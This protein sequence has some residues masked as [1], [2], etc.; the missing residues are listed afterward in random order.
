MF[1][2]AEL[3]RTT[4]KADYDAAL[5][6]LRARLLAAQRE[7]RGTRR[8]VIIVVS[9]VEGAGK[10]QVVNRLHEWLDA[11]GLTTH[12]FW[13]DS[14]EETERP[15][16]WRFW[17]ALPARGTIGILFGSWYTQ[18]IIDRV[19]GRSRRADLDRDLQRIAFFE[20]ML[21]D[22]GAVII[23]LW[24]HL[25][26]KEAKRR[27]KKGSVFGRFARMYDRFATVSERAIRM[28]DTAAAPW[29]I[30]EATDARYRDLTVGRIV[31][32]VLENLPRPAEKAAPAPASQEQTE[33][34]LDKVDLSK[35][36]SD[37]K[38]ERGL[39]KL[40]AEI[41]RLAWKAWNKRRSTV[42]LF[43]GWDA[44]GKGGA[45]RRLIAPI[46]ARLYRVIS[47][48]APTDE[49]R[50]R[51]YLWRFWRQLPRDGAMTLYDRSWYGRVLVE[52]VEGFAR[53]EEW[54]R[55][56]REIN[57]F[58][59][60]LVEHGI[61]LVKFWLHIDKAEQLRRFEERQ[62]IAFKQHKITDEDWRNREKWDPYTLAVH[63]MISRT[64]SAIAPWTIVAANDKR[65]A[66]LQVL[67]TVA[68]SLR[69]ED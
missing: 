52:R 10:S 26:E 65:L 46:D 59:E 6:E 18:P 33:S 58:E 22:D 67:E 13:R 40:Q 31:L 16:Y 62:K 11:R 19:F 29:R 37:K 2:A 63:D 25:P 20:Q 47:V 57:A 51:H 42:I 3:G 50:A 39:E 30:V 35:K 32:E 44:A 56:Y 54:G 23:K 34:V 15:R 12:A 69:P 48:A 9:G 53:P 66:R 1:E 14:D 5:P 61:V 55:A 68:N 60:E 41:A 28:T 27:R 24:F 64:S 38:Y 43:E 7:L 8:P 4:G 17:R 21:A 36:I 45:I 49:E